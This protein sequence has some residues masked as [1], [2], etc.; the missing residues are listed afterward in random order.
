[1]ELDNKKQFTRI[2]PPDSHPETLTRGKEMPAGTDIPLPKRF[3]NTTILPRV[4][5]RGQDIRLVVDTQRRYET[6]KPLGE[7]GGG[8]VELA[9]DKDIYRLVAIKRLKKGLQNTEMLMRFV[10]EIRTVGHLEHPNIVPIHDVG[11]D[12]NGR[13]YFVMKYVSGETLQSVIEKLSAGDPEYHKK[14]TYQ[15]R[16]EIFNEILKA[17]EFAHY[18]GI[19][20][21]DLKPANIMI[22]PHGEVMVMDWGIALRIRGKS[23]GL[24]QSETLKQFE[25]GVRE[26]E[27]KLPDK[28]RMYKT[29]VGTAIGT[30]AYMAPEQVTGAKNDERTDIYSLS[31]LFYEFL[32]LK[33]YLKPVNKLKKLL[34]GVLNDKPKQAML[35]A[36]KHQPAVPADLSHI[37]VKGLQKVPAARF[38]SVKEMQVLLQRIASGHTPVQC[39]FTFSKRT[40]QA[41]INLLSDHPMIGLLFFMILVSFTLGGVLFLVK[42]VLSIL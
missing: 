36:D 39:P 17:M 24:E 12:E 19:I 22:G 20:H 28:E 37:L 31:A 2:A 8:E 6:Q 16:T 38:Q 13:Y 40:F 27:Q 15:Y 26:A 14:Y 9:L 5:G 1:M 21:R 3:T 41:L 33:S 18:N 7:G 25:A 29:E 35:L 32:T 30:P 34:Q 4:E 42:Q 10:D 23:P 11:R